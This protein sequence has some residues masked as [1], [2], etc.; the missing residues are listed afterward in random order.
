MTN[1]RDARLDADASQTRRF[2]IGLARA[3]GGAIFF[4]LP[5]L[6]TME[7]WWLG[8]HMDRLRLAL[9][10]ALMI[11]LLIALDHYAGF[12]ETATWEEDVVDGMI[13]FGV[14]IV[15]SAVVLPLFNVVTPD[16]P[17]RES[18]GKIS[19]QAI[20]ASFGAVIATSQL[21][22]GDSEQQTN[23]RRATG[24]GAELL[25]MTAGAIFLAFNV[26][27]TEEMILL[28]FRMTAWHALALA[29]VSLALMH[30]FVY[31]VEFHGTPVA[32]EGTPGW[33]IFLRFTVVG[34]LLA[35]LVSAYVL[36]TFGRYDSG[37]FGVHVMEA[38]VLGFPAALG[39]AA[40]RLII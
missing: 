5:L 22:G 16:M 10:M 27:P 33:S 15:S 24:Y 17:L 39:A 18:I 7:M 38:I 9:F 35:L 1:A 23:R 40:A 4:S 12:K 28:A 19:L 2:W 21:G 29:L 26:A 13:A 34:Y 31:A 36:W 37:A 32:P 8:F 30:A 14:G 25:L 20:P 6:M 11:P 3:F